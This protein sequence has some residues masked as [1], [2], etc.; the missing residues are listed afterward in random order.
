M[1]KL[2]AGLL[3]VAGIIHLLP[4]PGVLGADRLLA[5][6]GVRLDDPNLIILMQHRAVLFGLLGFFLIGA[7]FKP[8]LQ[9]AAL[10][11]GLVSVVS[12]LFI[13]LTAEAYNAAILNIVI[14][15]V[16][17]LVALLVAAACYRFKPL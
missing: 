17:A 11:A 5:L 6:Y 1:T 7:A 4:L 9:P 16:V 2:I 10:I 13:A 12:F 14:A 15:D 3:I 8:A